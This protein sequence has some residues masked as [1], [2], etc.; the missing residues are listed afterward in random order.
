[1]GLRRFSRRCASYLRERRGGGLQEAG[2]GQ[3]V[4]DGVDEFGDA[5]GDDRGVAVA[6]MAGSFPQDDQAHAGGVANEASEEVTTPCR[7]ARLR[8]SL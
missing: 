6:G 3:G 5:A 1:M 2:A 7:I 4:G 8:C